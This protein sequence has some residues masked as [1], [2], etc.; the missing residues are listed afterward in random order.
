MFV[1]VNA[2]WYLLNYNHLGW[3]SVKKRITGSNIN[4]GNSAIVY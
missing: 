1:F 3:L 2:I 4:A